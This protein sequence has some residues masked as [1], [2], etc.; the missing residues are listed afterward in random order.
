MTLNANAAKIVE[1]MK[2]GTKELG[3]EVL[4]LE[5]GA[6]ILDCGV[7]V[8]GSIEAG[9]LFSAVCLGGL[10]E[11]SISEGNYGGLKLPTVNM[12]T[13]QP[14]IACIAS[15]KAG[16]RIKVGEF[17]ALGSGP[18]RVLAE[19]PKHGYTENSEVA[20][21][22]LECATLPDADVAS[23]VADKC[24][25]DVKN[26]SMLAARTASVVGS[27]Q[28]SA[29]MVETALFKMDRLGF[30]VEA[31]YASGTAPIAPIVGDDA[32]MMGA[33]NDMII[34]GSQ[35]Y[36][37]AKGNLDVEAIPSASSRDYGVPFLEVFKRSGHDF[38]KID[39]GIFA[40]AE[41][42]VENVRTGEVKS[43]GKINPQMIEK[44]LETA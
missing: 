43:A 42:T 5:N 38:Y 44:T 32:Q 40:P 36:L 15:Q 19:R 22:A 21:L 20:V 8:R 4:E 37:K 28:V 10:A 3:I 30:D 39:Q 27:T 6:T 17:F 33:T 35:V 26:L 41:I 18:A 9:R 29:R 1:G 34:Y 14:Q 31:V 11:V 25:I 16:W 2:G 12:E 7:K 23:Y 13:S 24:D